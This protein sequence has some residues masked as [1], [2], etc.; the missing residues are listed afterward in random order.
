MGTVLFACRLALGLVFAIAGLAKLTNWRGSVRAA[1]EFGASPGL[2]RAVGVVLP[3]VELALAGALLA[4]PSAR[5]GATAAG[6]LL[7]AFTA[8]ILRAMRR[9]ERPDCHCFGQL[10]SAAVGPLTL[11]RNGLLAAVAVV[12][13]V[14]GWNDAGTSATGWVS[15]LDATQA[16]GL[17]VAALLT[18]AIVGLT[19]FSLSLLRQNGRILHRLDELERSLGLPAGEGPGQ[20]AGMA[21]TVGA[22]AP[23]FQLQALDGGLVTLTSL[24]SAAKPVLLVFSDPGCG[25]CNALLPEVARWQ[26]E[27]AARITIALVSRG[28]AADNRAKREEHGLGLL[29][30]QE[31]RELALRYGAHATPSAVLISPGGT[32]S[33]PPAAGAPAIRA[34]VSRAAAVLELVPSEG[35]AAEG[36]LG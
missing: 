25:P 35:R 27:H 10:H 12:V 17:A 7:I 34:L 29:L 4:R 6:L 14:A 36:A 13:A 33:E 1:R 23:D 24:Q 2:A 30:M 31:D 15:S 19:W 20:A 5:W 26:L 3:P 8:V 28:S 9:G 22:S 16:V 32:I 11:V 21:L 18:S